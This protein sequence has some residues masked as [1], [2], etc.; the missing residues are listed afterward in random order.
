MRCRK[1]AFEFQIQISHRRSFGVLWASSSASCTDNAEESS[2]ILRFS[3][4]LATILKWEQE[5]R[6]GR[7]VEMLYALGNYA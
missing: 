6:T 1:N 3:Q 2:L 4:K 5:A 7:G